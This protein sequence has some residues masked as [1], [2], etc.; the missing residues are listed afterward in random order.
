MQ[1]VVTPLVGLERGREANDWEMDMMETNRGGRRLGRLTMVIGAALAL[2]G[3]LVDCSR[4]PGM[5]VLYRFDFGDDYQPVAPGYQPVSRVYRSPR[6]L[7]VGPVS[8]G[9]RVDNPDPLLRDF[10]TGNRGE[11][12]V[13]LDN[14]EYRITAIM[15]DS[16]QAHGPFTIY[17]QDH[18]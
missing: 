16:A 12:R 14:G 7:W 1:G 6:F 3:G 11:F 2:A 9:D 8:E 5:E 15:S 18:S 4:Q 10:E 13:G 17:A